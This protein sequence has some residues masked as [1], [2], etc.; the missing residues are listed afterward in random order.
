MGAE[1]PI[2]PGRLASRLHNKEL[3][4]Q[5]KTVWT[6]FFQMIK[7]PYPKTPTYP[8]D[9]ASQM[10][11]YFKEYASSNQFRFEVD[12]CQ[13]VCIS[14]TP[15]LGHENDREIVVQGHHDAVFV[16]EPDPSLYGVNPVITEDGKWVKG[17]GTNLTADNRLGDAIAL[18]AVESLVKSGEKHGPIKILLTAGEDSGL[19]G[20]THLGETKSKFLNGNQTLINVDSSEGPEW[21]TI[22][23]ASGSRDNLAIPVNY[24]TIGNKK[25]VKYTFSGFPGGH[26]GLDIGKDRPSSIKFF[27]ELFS[28]LKQKFPH[29]GL[30]L[31][32]AGEAFNAI[33]ASASFILAVDGQDEIKVKEFVGQYIEKMKTNIPADASEEYKKARININALTQPLSNEEQV[34]KYQLS[35]DTSELLVNALLELPQGVGQRDGESILSSNNIGIVQQ[36]EDGI[37][38]QVMTRGRETSYRDKLRKVI[39]QTAQ[40]HKLLLEEKLAYRH[41]SPQPDRKIVSL[42]K[43]LGKQLLK[44]EMM[45]RV[46]LGGLEP[47]IF[48]GDFPGLEAISISVAVIKDEH[49]LQERAEID[50]LEEGY[51]LLNVLLTELPKAYNPL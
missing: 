39:K 17:D 6:R 46:S 32:K 20:A 48:E 45:T 34:I 44:K 27:A 43:E 25:L 9:D 10:I 21:I 29:T 36:E 22:G 50:S 35:R 15:S 2:S 4:Q 38:I 3:E 37:V 41:W 33:P 13:N 42:A 49:S 16:G 30:V 23:C 40:R 1:Q 14:V 24:E 5:L 51:L 8:H 26:S 28:I 18:T 19:I 7:I 12:R 47:G 11:N 31:V